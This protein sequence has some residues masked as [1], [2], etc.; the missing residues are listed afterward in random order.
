MKVYSV[1]MGLRIVCI[2]GAVLID[3][4]WARVLLIAGAALLPW[5]AVMLANRGAD[6]SERTSSVYRP[7][8][9]TE[10]PTTAQAQ[11][12]APDPGTVVVD[13]EYT[14]QRSPRELP[15]HRPSATRR[16]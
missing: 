3:N 13:G 11:E 12:H 14:V 16:N 4:L 6:R 9:R 5:F 7:P 10:L 15:A 1:Q 8:T 2:I